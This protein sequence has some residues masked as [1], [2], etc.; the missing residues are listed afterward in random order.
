MCNWLLYINNY[1]K[2]TRKIEK[3]KRKYLHNTELVQIKKHIK[4]NLSK[5]NVRPVINFWLY[6]GNAENSTFR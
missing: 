1:K 3:K 6:L 4:G 5:I 2:A